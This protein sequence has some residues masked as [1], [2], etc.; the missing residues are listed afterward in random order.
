MV[1]AK[2]KG[3]KGKRHVGGQ[4]QLSFH[5]PVPKRAALAPGAVASP[6]PTAPAAAAVAR[7]AVR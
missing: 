3:P 2:V 7:R 4:T 6:V 1:D 5:S